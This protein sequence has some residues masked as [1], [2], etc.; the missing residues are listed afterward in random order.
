M[1]SER[2]CPSHKPQCSGPSLFFGFFFFFFFAN[3]CEK[4]AE[5]A[6]ESVRKPAQFTG[7][8]RP[9]PS[10]S[11]WLA[12]YNAYRR[13]GGACRVCVTRIISLSRG[14]PRG[15]LTGRGIKQDTHSLHN[16]RSKLFFLCC[17]NRVRASESRSR[18]GREG[19]ASPVKHGSGRVQDC[20]PCPST[21]S[22]GQ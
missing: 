8:A 5:K 15:A 9:G 22:V 13:C 18:K 3:G 17:N 4:K 10:R 1:V 19:K 21:S 7:R 16:C 14:V 2:K 12:T 11:V 6:N 20:P